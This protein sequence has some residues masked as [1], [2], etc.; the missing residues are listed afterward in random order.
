MENKKPFEIIAARFNISGESAKYFLGNIQKSFK[1]KKPPLQL[2]VDFIKTQK[3]K[4]LPEPHQVATRLKDLE[5]W[6]EPM[7]AAPPALQDEP[8]IY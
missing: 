6:Q 8:D 4:A 2:I 3:Y 5:L 7:H 1:G